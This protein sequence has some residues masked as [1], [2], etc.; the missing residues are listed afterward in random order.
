MSCE[1]ADTVVRGLISK[2]KSLLDTNPDAKPE[3]RLKVIFEPLE[4]LGILNE[5][6]TLTEVIGPPNMPRVDKQF[7]LNM[8][9]EFG[10]RENLNLEVFYL[11]VTHFILRTTRCQQ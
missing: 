3:E 11:T 2:V 9:K 4:K 8:Y 5:V 6:I 10:I 1:Y 7:V